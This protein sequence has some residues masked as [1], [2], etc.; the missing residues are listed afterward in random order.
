MIETFEPLKPQLGG[1]T[2]TGTRKVRLGD[3][4]S[5]GVLRLDGLTRYTQ[6]VSDDDTTDAGL[7]PVPS[8]V[9]RSTVVDEIQ[10][11]HLAEQLEFVTFCAG[12]GKRW[13]E[14]RLT[15]TGSEGARY[16]V[17]TI[18]VCVDPTSGQPAVLT[19]QF[20]SLYGAAAGDR[21]ASARLTNPKL[22][23]D[24]AGEPIANGQFEEYTTEQWQLR[25]GDFDVQH[26]VNNAAYWAAVNNWLPDAVEVPRR[27]RLEYSEGIPEQPDVLVTRSAQRETENQ[28]HRYLDGFGLWW[29]VDSS[30]TKPVA[31][32]YA[33]R[34]PTN[35][36]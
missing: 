27:C 10:P 15:V 13:A 23:F 32:F 20:F 4:D 6:D 2:F 16:E 25:R 17:A 26:H 1:R 3:V 14:R 18:W 28:D 8:W 11:A 30:A 21:L 22:K 7:D 35:L 29:R 19:D 5:S 33:C 24:E 34:L 9:V 12:V 31:S 36:Y